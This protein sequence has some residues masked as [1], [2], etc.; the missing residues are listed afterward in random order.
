MN[1]PLAIILAVLGWVGVGEAEGRGVAHSNSKRS[2]REPL[3][4]RATWH[5][6]APDHDFLRA[7]A[8]L[9]GDTSETSALPIDSIVDPTRIAISEALC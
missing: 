4:P 3:P 9:G 5:R 7:A 6:T 2:I 1:K 8:P